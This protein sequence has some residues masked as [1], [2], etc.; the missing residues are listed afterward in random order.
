VL[1]F[2]KEHKKISIAVCVMLVLIIFIRGGISA[3]NEKLKQEEADALTQQ[4]LEEANQGVT[5]EEDSLLMQMQP[6][7]IESFGKVPDG[8]IWESDG[9]LLSLGDKSMSAEEVVYSYFRGLASLDISTVER[10]S[11]DSKVVE[12]YSTYFDSKNKNTDYMD[13]FLRNMYKECLLSLQIEGID[14]NA[15]FAANKQVFTVKAKVLDLTNKD[16]WKKDEMEIYKNLYLYDQDESDTTKSDMYLYSYILDY[17]ESGEAL[18]R[19][20]TFDITVEKYPDLDSG[21]LVSIDNDVDDA[22]S[23]KDGKLVVSYIKELYR[24]VG[25]DEVMQSMN[26][27]N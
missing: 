15:V 3:R 16:F 8:F 24:N 4:L 21:W 13:Q 27:S 1:D 12:S 10:Y 23:Y 5:D 22:C 18:L 20:V 14:S 7:L 9:T 25:R 17:Y 11:R 26:I 6:E 2:I 19:D